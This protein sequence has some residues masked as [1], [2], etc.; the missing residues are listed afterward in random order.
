MP[1]WLNWLPLLPAVVFLVVVGPGLL[2]DVAVHMTR[3]D[4]PE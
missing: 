3:E 1:D 4:L 2:R